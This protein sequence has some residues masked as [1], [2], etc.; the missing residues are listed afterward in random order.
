MVNVRVRV[1]LGLGLMSALGWALTF[2]FYVFDILVRTSTLNS[3]PSS[4]TY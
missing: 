2:T 1:S 4:S 3:W